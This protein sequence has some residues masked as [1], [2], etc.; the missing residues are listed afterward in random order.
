MEILCSLTGDLWNGLKLQIAHQET[1]RCHPKV[2]H[3][4]FWRSRSDMTMLGVKK[5]VENVS[6][7]SYSGPIIQSSKCLEKR[8]PRAN[9]LKHFSKVFDAETFVKTVLEAL[10]SFRV[11]KPLIKVMSRDGQLMIVWTESILLFESV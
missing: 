6:W 2:I 5:S 10:K 3:Q 9:K 1:A 4:R 8:L 7:K 11:A